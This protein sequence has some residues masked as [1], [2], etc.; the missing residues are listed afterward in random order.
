MAA[1]AMFSARFAVAIEGRPAPN[2]LNFCWLFILLPRF[3]R[4]VRLRCRFNFLGLRA[5]DLLR[6]MLLQSK[7]DFLPCRCRCCCLFASLFQFNMKMT[8]N[9][10]N[11][12]DANSAADNSFCV[13]VTKR[14]AF[15]ANC[16]F[17]LIEII[18]AGEIYCRTDRRTEIVRCALRVLSSKRIAISISTLNASNANVTW[19]LL[20]VKAWGVCPCSFITATQTH[21][22][23]ETTQKTE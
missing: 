4:S 19:C 14:K 11:D 21:T 6:C 12:C 9:C 23:Y 1:M 16:K 18:G 2:E 10:A 22:R 5:N 17:N 20:Y 15:F 7:C 8:T 3:P 13:V